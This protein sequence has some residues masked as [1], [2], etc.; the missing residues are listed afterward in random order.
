VAADHV[1]GHLHALG[2]ED[3]P[4]AR[5]AADQALALEAADHPGDAGRRYLHRPGQVGRRPL[6]A[7]LAQRLGSL[8]STVRRV[9]SETVKATASL[10]KF[11][12]ALIA[13]SFEG[14]KSLLG[15]TN[16]LSRSLASAQSALSSV[17]G[18]LA[19][20]ATS[21]V[22]G[23]TGL[24]AM[25][26]AAAL[27]VSV[28]AALVAVVIVAAAPFATLL[29]F[30]LL[31]PGALGVVLGI[32]APLVIALHGLGDALGL[33]FEKDPKKFADGF[34]KLSPVMQDVTRTL[35]TFLPLFTSIQRSVQRN[36][37]GP[38]LKAL[39]P[40]LRSI[41]PSLQRGLAQAAAA[42]G[43]FVAQ[44]VALLD[45]PAFRT[46][47]ADLFPA[48]T[49]IIQAMAPV[50]IHLMS[51]LATVATAA[52]P[53][54][55]RLMGTL[56]GFIDRF[57]TWL[58]TVVADGRFQ[59]F[60]DDAIASAQSI[61]NLIKALILLFVELFTATDK[62]GQKF[63]DKI[64]AAVNEFTK[65]LK[66][67]DGK[68]A[69]QDAVVLA[70]AF[71]AA[72]KAALAVVRVI[73]SELSKAFRIGLD[74]LRLIGVINKA[75]PHVSVLGKAGKSYSGGGVV[76]YDQIAMVH[77]GEPI[78]DPA[79]SADKNRS[80]LADAGM[81]DLL[82]QPNVT[83]VYVGGTKFAEYVDYRISTANRSQATSVKY[84]ARTS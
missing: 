44:A 42:M 45:T 55:E 34:K 48:I 74:L 49:R 71:A 32:I 53:T 62:G 58:E 33:V 36:F 38:V 63:L 41:G 18:S 70:V 20:L 79:N 68:K 81:L 77:K 24:A 25:A 10:A 64:T 80:I 83:N 8:F 78:L 52:L 39:V 23:A 19:S 3:D 15:F 67:P 54:I 73:V 2:G 16:D 5:A 66:S 22:S 60:L 11:G 9:T 29:N 37:L 56:G 43:A 47:I 65:W 7:G 30:A 82:S 50:L 17:A 4:L 31:L 27:L 28:L 6:D 84:G 46:F 13:V 72:F 51:A 26:A 14:I 1:L 76:G 21:A 12:G 75:D 61:W 57:A 40:V 35:R 59:Q 69:L